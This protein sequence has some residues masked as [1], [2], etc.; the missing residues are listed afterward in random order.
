M[1][2]AFTVDLKNPK[3]LLPFDSDLAKP[4]PCSSIEAFSISS[5][6]S[7]IRPFFS[8]SSPFSTFLDLLLPPAK[9]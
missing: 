9:I 8:V 2:H 1:R 3:K 6:R 5:I 4:C 7:T